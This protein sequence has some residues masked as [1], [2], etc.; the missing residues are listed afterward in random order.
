VKG[1]RSCSAGPV[2]LRGNICAE[3][4]SLRTR[5]G[6]SRGA[7]ISGFSKVTAAS[8]TVHQARQMAD[9]ILA[10]SGNNRT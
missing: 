6:I 3:N 9:L 10:V 7:W 1:T 2:C 5:R 8:V 4:Y